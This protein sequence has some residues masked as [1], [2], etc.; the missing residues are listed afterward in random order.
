[1]MEARYWEKDRDGIA[2][3]RLCPRNCRIKPGHSG[4]C[5]TRQNRE[6]VLWNVTAGSFIS[7]NRDPV[8]KKPLYHFFPGSMTVSVGSLGCNLRCL[9]CQN[10]TL[11]HTA[12]AE[13]LSLLQPLSA[14][15]LVNETAAVGAPLL[16]FT[17]NEPLLQFEYLLEAAPLARSM[18]LQTVLVTAG[19]IAP[20]PLKELL[21]LID[22]WRVDIKGWPGDFYR[23]LTGGDWLN[24]VLNNTK[25]AFQAG[26]HV[27][28]VTNIIPNWNDRPE[29]LEWIAEWIAGELSPAV[30]WHVTAYHPAH[31]MQEPPTPVATIEQAITIG[32]KAGLYHTFAGNIPGHAGQDTLC[33]ACKAVLIRRSGFRVTENLLQ[34]NRCPHCGRT[35]DNFRPVYRTD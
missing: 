20:E 18:G 29:Q 6:G 11:S 14:E 1:M 33:P 3:C 17:Y 9:H 13:N 34:E 25:A 23:R 7:L 31:R 4:F 35:L 24:T 5:S 10:S 22:A 26:V 2:V 12:A 8:E 16:V 32:R 27:E 28:A 19:L 15:A 21:P 30:P